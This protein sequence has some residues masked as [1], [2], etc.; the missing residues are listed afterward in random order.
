MRKRLDMLLVLACGAVF[1]GFIA[2]ASASAETIRIAHSTWVGYG[3]LYIAQQKGIFKENGVDVELIVIEDPKESFPTMMA[4][5]VQLIASTVVTAPLYLKKATDFQYVVAID[6]SNG[7]D[8]IVANKDITSIAGLKGKRVAVN[9]GSISQFYLDVLLANAGLRESDLQTVN[10]TA[11]DAGSAFVSKRVDAAVT[12]EPW[13][14]KGKASDHGHL[15]VDSSTTPG[16]ITDVVVAK[17]A[18]VNSHRKEVEAIVK[19]WNE[20]VAYYRAN[21]DESIAIMAKGVGGWLKDPKDFKE[22]LSGIKF[23][24]GD[25]NKA[26]FGTKT[27]PGPIYRTV[28]KAID[29]WSSHGKLQVKVTPDE[30]INDS[31]V[32]G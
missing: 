16:L 11:G 6:D 4:D 13:L 15:L 30:L 26:F 27:N 12:W 25:D 1:G 7:G 29:V 2:T 19:S 17:T 21:P 5:K 22:S 28:E 31:F 8:G 3:P 32:N 20:A 23:F 18:W 10:M 24:G 14:S 9:E